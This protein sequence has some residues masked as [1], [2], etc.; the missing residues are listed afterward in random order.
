MAENR[1]ISP[2]AYMTVALLRDAPP[3]GDVIF[4][5]TDSVGSPGGLKSEVLKKLG[6]SD[7]LIPNAEDLAGGYSFV[8]PPKQG[9][10]CFI[11]TVGFDDR[12]V[13]EALSRNLTP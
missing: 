4:V 2:A 13:S 9:R 8:S 7:D 1:P 11:V 10:I 3:F 12:N 6:L 5:S